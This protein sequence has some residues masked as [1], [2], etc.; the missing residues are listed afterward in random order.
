MY[1]AENEAQLPIV[2]CCAGGSGGAYGKS[3]EVMGQVEEQNAVSSTQPSPQKKVLVI[4]DNPTIV[5]LIRHAVNMQGK[6]SVVVAYDGVQ[7]LERFNAERPDCVIVDVRM[8]RMD[9]YQ[10]V[11]CLRGD[12]ISA[13]TP[14]I[15]LS[16]MIEEDDQLTGLLSGVDEYL[17]KPFKPSVLCATLERVM[18]ITEEER[19][20]RIER[21]AMQDMQDVQNELRS[22]REQKPPASR[23]TAV[24][25]IGEERKDS[26]MPHSTAVSAV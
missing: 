24:A 20:V 7:G 6:Y 8:P 22:Q 5:E 14:L 4:D 19:A 13:H 3:G 2:G 11:R 25:E 17:A 16:A 23:R 21:M 15:I 18:Q 1:L 26:D 12:S 10:V 9:G